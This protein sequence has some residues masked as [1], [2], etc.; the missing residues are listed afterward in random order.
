M[1]KIKAFFHKND[2][3]GKEEAP[4]KEETPVTVE[5]R[6]DVQTPGEPPVATPGAALPEVLPEVHFRVSEG[7]PPAYETGENNGTTASLYD[8]DSNLSLLSSEFG[9]EYS[10]D[11]MSEVSGVA[12]VGAAAAALFREQAELRDYKLVEKIGEGAFSKVFRATPLDSAF[13]ARGYKQVAVKVIRKETLQTQDRE[14]ETSVAASFSSKNSKNKSST[15]EQVL[16]EVALHKKVSP[17]CRYI[18]Q[19]LDFIETPS[20][21]YIVQELLNGGEIFN[22]IVRFT[23]LSEDLSRHVARQLGKAVRHLH[24]MGVVHRDIKP[25]NL[26]F[27]PIDIAPSPQGQQHFR[28]SDDPNTKLDEGVFTPGVGGGGIGEVKLADFGLSKQIYQTSTKT[29]CGTVGYTAPEVVKDERYSMKVDMWGVGC[30]LYTMLCGFPPFYDDKIDVLTEKIS[31]GAYTFLQPWWDEISPGAKHCV[32]K[33]LE[34]DPVHRYDI[35]EFLADPWLNSY[36]CQPAP[37]PQQEA[38]AKHAHKARM[39]ARKMRVQFN[40]LQDSD[41]LY[42]PAAVAMRDAFDISNAVARIEEERKLTPV[43]GLGQLQEED[44]EDESNFG[45]LPRDADET[46]SLD[47]RKL[48]LQEQQQ[49]RA[50]AAQQELE[51]RMFHLKLDAS[52]IVKRRRERRMEA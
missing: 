29:P 52:T 49:Q 33:L 3:Q 8:S 50:A 14:S 15:R 23:Y 39:R 38:E 47:E 30:V 1:N 44:G 31:R 42:S 26:L 43:Y 35:D 45:S 2:K 4:G 18:V 10:Y 9:S 32:G 25:E 48:R 46:A 51:Q 11:D 41:V 27:N 12:G 19:F 21:Y 16:K 34:V 6:E 5:V 17:G 20:C 7:L 37:Q 28:K 22:E 13:P 36:D 40:H 24:R